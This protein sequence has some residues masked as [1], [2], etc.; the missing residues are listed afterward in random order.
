MYIYDNGKKKSVQNRQIQKPIN[1]K[2]FSESKNNIIQC[3]KE[4]GQ[5]YYSNNENIAI[6]KI[7]RPKEYYSTNTLL[8]ES[9]SKLDELHSPVKLRKASG[10]IS[11]PL[12]KQLDKIIPEKREGEGGLLTKTECIDVASEI[13]NTPDT[14]KW[15]ARIREFGVKLEPFQI[16]SIHS[17]IHPITTSSSDRIRSDEDFQRYT[18]QK[19][20]VDDKTDIP[21]KGNIKV[22]IRTLQI[23]PELKNKIWGFL[24]DKEITFSCLI[25]FFN[26]LEKTE[27]KSDNYYQIVSEIYLK[28][29]SIKSGAFAYDSRQPHVTSGYQINE[30]AQARLGE[31]LAIISTVPRELRRE[32]TWNFHFAAVIAKDESDVMTLEN[33]TG[34][35]LGDWTFHMYGDQKGQSF[36]EQHKPSMDNP[37]TVPVSPDRG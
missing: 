7:G 28:A 8:E 10:S 14:S 3:Y 24:R 2:V 25:H 31:A 22:Y 6:N 35:E 34:E 12:L 18:G 36:H 29:Q 1:N 26:I 23:I 16:E 32:E 13:L 5:Y 21:G 20:I 19:V 27:I 9:N 33:S 17:L 11:T 30:N 4:E 37:I 15:V